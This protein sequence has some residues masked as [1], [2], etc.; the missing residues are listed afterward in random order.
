MIEEMSLQTFSKNS[1][2]GRR[3][4]FLRGRV[5]DSREA[6]TGKARSL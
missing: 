5:F 6:S 1:Q 3:R 2:W 4:D